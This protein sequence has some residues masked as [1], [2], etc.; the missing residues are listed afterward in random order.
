MFQ[1][2]EENIAA[3]LSKR[4]KKTIDD[5][6]LKT[7]A[8]LIPLFQK[9]GEFHVLL[10]KRTDEVE[11]HKGQICFPGGGRDAED[12]TLCDTAL[13]EAFEEIGLETRDVR[14]LGELDDSITATSNFLVSPFV[15]VIP[16]PYRFI[17]N[18]REVKELLEVP[19]SVF[20]TRDNY[21]EK[22][23]SDGKS[24]HTAYFVDYGNYV[25]WGATANILRHFADVLLANMQSPAVPSIKL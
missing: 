6:S 20:L 1:P 17:P 5:S 7:A 8:V 3:I 14:I 11:Y 25:I 2:T 4:S 16:H 12:K 9:N 15:A 24:D 21:K 22:S 10:M 19:L 23:V 13:R 18:K